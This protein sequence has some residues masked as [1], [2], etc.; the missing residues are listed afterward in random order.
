MSLI[1][2]LKD[3]FEWRAYEK[4]VQKILD[5]KTPVIVTW[6]LRALT[7]I[8]WEH[9]Y[10][11]IKLLLKIEHLAQDH[12]TKSIILLPNKEWKNVLNFI[13][14]LSPPQTPVELS[15]DAVKAVNSQPYYQ[16]KEKSRIM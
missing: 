6:D 14:R 11:T 9:V 16:Y 8:P 7:K 12:I 5:Y 15:I 10:K 2:R 4:T 13:F 3:N 1:V